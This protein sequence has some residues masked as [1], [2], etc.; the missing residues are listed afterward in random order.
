M[1][2]LKQYV[3]QKNRWDTI[4]GAPA[5]DLTN[6]QDRQRI[7]ENIDSDLSPENLTCDGELPRAQVRARYTMLTNAARELLELDPTVTFSEYA[8]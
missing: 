6:P 7:A 2:H 5:L 4:F 1:K 3:D 8:E